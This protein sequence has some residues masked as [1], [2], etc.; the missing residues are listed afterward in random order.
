MITNNKK[1]LVVSIVFFILSFLTFMYFKNGTD[2]K[3]IID[4]YLFFNVIFITILSTVVCIILAV[5][6]L[7]A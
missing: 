6:F 5:V 3:S 2:Y 7:S 4:K 1:Q